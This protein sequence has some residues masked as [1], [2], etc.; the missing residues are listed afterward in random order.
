MKVDDDSDDEEYSSSYALYV[1]PPYYE[2]GTDA[3]HLLES[4]VK[5]ARDDA[6]AGVKRY[7]AKM[8]RRV[9]DAFDRIYVDIH[10][11]LIAQLTKSKTKKG[12]NSK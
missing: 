10:D 9:D 4:Y 3:I 1:E 7:A 5:A 11:S 6:K 8:E 2:D 12:P